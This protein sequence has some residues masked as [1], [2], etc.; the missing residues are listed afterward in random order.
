MSS[1]NETK[2]NRNKQEELMVCCINVFVCNANVVNEKCV[3]LITVMF[4]QAKKFILDTSVCVCAYRKKCI[5][6]NVHVRKNELSRF[7]CCY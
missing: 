4:V 7:D 5:K 3:H 1:E 6:L 2:Q